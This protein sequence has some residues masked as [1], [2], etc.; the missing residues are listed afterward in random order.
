MTLVS[1]GNK[2]LLVQ[3]L[4]HLEVVL[5]YF[6][7][8]NCPCLDGKCAVVLCCVFPCDACFTLCGFP[9][10]CI[11]FSSPNVAEMSAVGK[12]VEDVI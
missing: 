5:V 3:I 4:K 6:S 8:C 2:K 1:L 10:G 11:C 7:G 9:S 12:A